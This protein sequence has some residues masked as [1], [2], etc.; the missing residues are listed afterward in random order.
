MRTF[1]AV[2]LSDLVRARLA[3][4]KDARV[5]TGA[6]VRWV[7]AESLHLTLKF[8][9]EVD[10]LRVPELAQAMR[11]VAG[12][13]TPLRLVVR[14]L[15]CFP[16]ARSPR[17]FWAGLDAEPLLPELAR[18]IEARFTQLGFAAE[19]RPFKSH[20]TLARITGR[21]HVDREQL[22]AERPELGAWTVKRIVLM[23]STPARG[24][25]HYCVAAEA[26]LAAAP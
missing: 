22:L 25:A 5:V 6:R 10:P 8:L 2:E 14:G 4:L 7:A 24:G 17:I 19:D 13:F 26:P 15:G 1:I 23:E 3:A 16:D 20:V 9:G 12:R 11:A 18:A 21:A